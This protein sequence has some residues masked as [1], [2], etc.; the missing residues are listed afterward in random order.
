MEWVSGNAQIWRESTASFCCILIHILPVDAA[1][2]PTKTRSNINYHT[3]NAYRIV[4]RC[5]RASTRP[6]PLN[7]LLLFVSNQYYCCSLKN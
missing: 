4:C 3:T 2:V 7:N 5:P 6:A 1:V